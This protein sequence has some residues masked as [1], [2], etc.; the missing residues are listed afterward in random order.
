MGDILTGWGAA[1][2]APTWGMIRVHSGA[3]GTPESRMCP[4]AQG[5]GEETR[6]SVKL[7]TASPTCEKSTRNLA[8]GCCGGR[9]L[10]QN[11]QIVRVNGAE[12]RVFAFD[13]PLTHQRNKRFF[14]TEGTFF[15]G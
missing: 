5:D 3:G 11:V 9:R 12:Q 4:A 1:C 6:R 10:Q 14:Q 13:V 7:G 8:V 2:C 15:L